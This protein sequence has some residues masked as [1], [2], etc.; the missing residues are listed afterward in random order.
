[1]P[2]AS[3]NRCRRRCRCSLQ[4]SVA[5]AAASG[6]SSVPQCS[7]A[8]FGGH[9]FPSFTRLLLRC[10]AVRGGVF[11]ISLTFCGGAG[12]VTGSKHLLEVDGEQHLVDCGMFQGLKELRNHN[13]DNPSFDPTSLASVLLTHAHMDHTGW[14]P[15][16]GKL[17]FQGPVLCTPATLDLVRILLHDAAHLQ[18]EDA[19]F[20]N[21]KGL[22]KHQPALPLYDRADVDRVLKQIRTHP[23]GEWIDLSRRVR[24]RFRDAG[25]LLGSA[26]IDV[27]ARDTS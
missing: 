14:L 10:S 12:T 5:L 6:P 9:S 4:G 8:R 13:W 27:V 21:R 19:E 2:L 23:Y 16:L 24:V 17:G 7:G 25:H 15:R 11:L 22:S 18:E 20:L 26:M 1:R 3:S